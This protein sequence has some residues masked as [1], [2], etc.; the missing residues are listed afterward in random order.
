MRVLYC[1]ETNRLKNAILGTETLIQ[2]MYPGMLER[3]FIYL[4]AY[5]FH[6]AVHP[7]SYV[8][9]S[10]LS[11][12]SSVFAE[13]AI[14]NQRRVLRDNNGFSVYMDGKLLL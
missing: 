11:F 9:L 10:Y 7:F 4:D 3:S 8:S 14:D 12:N 5:P 2:R 6:K 13:N 1:F